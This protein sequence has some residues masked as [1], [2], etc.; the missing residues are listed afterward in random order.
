VRA[1]E[2]RWRLRVHKTRGKTR[3]R[4]NGSLTDLGQKA[5]APPLTDLLRR[6]IALVDHLGP[7]GYVGELAREGAVGAC[8]RG[9]GFVCYCAREVGGGERGLG[10]MRG[11]D[12]GWLELTVVW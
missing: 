6:T 3:M 9:G 11:G 4:K 12:G 1:C 10:R 7:W 8:W 5:L 2:R